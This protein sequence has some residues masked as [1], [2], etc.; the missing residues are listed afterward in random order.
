MT[1][2]TSQPRSAA[3]RA[4]IIAAVIWQIGS[5]FLPALG[6]GE[7]I[8]DR[9]D[10][11]RTLVVPSGWAFAIWGPLFLGCA[12]FAIW[13]ALPA[14]RNNALLDKIGWYAAGATAAQGAWATYTQFYNLTALSVIIIVFSLLCLLAILRQLTTWR[15]PFST[16]ERWIAALT[17]SALAAWLTVASTVNIV[18]ALKYH[19]VGG[20]EEYPKLAGA[21][22]LIAGIIGAEAAQRSRG[23][24]WYAAVILWA[25]LAIY[26]KNG[27]QV[28]EIALATG[29]SAVFVIL[30]CG[31][32]LKT[33][34]NRRHWLGG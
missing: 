20:A 24:P 18:A 16:G 11:I 15:D 4:A 21:I 25:M 1:Y 32:G 28:T 10:A 14:Q 8:G 5:T 34:G 23:N 13:Q 17:F 19:G 26:F 33:A 6:L 27:Q 9:S 22:V 2:I 12:V 3:Q 31:R 29:F 30:G 7:Q